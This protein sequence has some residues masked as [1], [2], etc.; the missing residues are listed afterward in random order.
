MNIKQIENF[1]GK[2]KENAI[3]GTF[4]KTEDPA[5]V[6]CMGYAGFD[7]CIIDMEHGPN[8]I[9]SIQALVRAA[10]LAGILPIVRI[11]E[12]DFNLISAALD[13]G[14]AGVQVPQI[15]S[16]KSAENAIRHAR[17]APHGM[18][19][20]CRYV[21]NARYSAELPETYFKG[22][23]EALVVL[24]M[25]GIEALKNLDEILS[26][27]GIDVMFVGPYDLSQSLGVTGQPRHPSVVE[28]VQNI[29]E[30]C[31]EKGIA[32]GTFVESVDGAEYW[33]SKGVHYLSY[34]VDVGIFYSACSNIVA[35]LHSSNSSN[36]SQP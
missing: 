20:V 26:V 31:A 18:R 28:A 15:D 24:Q 16:A 23:N 21:R 11:P 3:Y 14:A 2:I 30:K 4:S 9:R 1:R 8:S 10:E 6:E 25:E 29:A 17:Y 19:G 5:F 34:A 27:E 33:R 32:V 35:Q 12:G 36:T 22:A 13:V 7:Y